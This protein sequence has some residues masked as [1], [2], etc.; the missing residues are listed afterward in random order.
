MAL[1]VDTVITQEDNEFPRRQ[2]ASGCSFDDIVWQQA[3]G[4][5]KNMDHNCRVLGPPA[6]WTHN[7]TRRRAGASAG[8][9][10][11]ASR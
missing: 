3:I 9:K 2:Y 11:V 4:A 5:C 8:R 1:L 10:S 7:N 6:L